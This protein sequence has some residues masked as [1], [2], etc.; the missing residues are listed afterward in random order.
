MGRDLR[1]NLTLDANLPIFSCDSPGG[2]HGEN[3]ELIEIVTALA[4]TLQLSY[5]NQHLDIL[6][7]TTNGNIPFSSSVD[8]SAGRKQALVA[9]VIRPMT[10]LRN[11]QNKRILYL[12]ETSHFVRQKY[13]YR[14]VVLQYLLNHGFDYV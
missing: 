8:L 1:C 2:H 9:H 5:S 10:H 7:E 13:D 4:P 6:F 12:D 3:E 11:G 14:K